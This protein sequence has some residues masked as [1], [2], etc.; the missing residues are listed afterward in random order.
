MSKNDSSEYL[1]E[2]IS[3][4][5]RSCRINYAVGAL[6]SIIILGYSV[7]AFWLVGN[8]TDSEKISN[9]ALYSTARNAP[10]VINSLESTLI[11]QAPEVADSLSVSL[12][13]MIP[14]LRMKA[15]DTL[16]QM[17]DESFETSAIELINLTNAYLDT[18]NFQLK[19]DNETIEVYA[20][21][22]ADT[23]ASDFSQSLEKQLVNTLG[24]TI[25]DVNL[26][27]HTVLTFL[28]KHL[29]ELATT[30]EPSLTRS[31]QLERLLI[32]YLIRNYMPKAIEEPALT[33]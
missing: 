15:Q 23:L 2:Q 10:K 8:F 16:R 25:D 4:L 20:Q 33:E 28:N 29:T 22:V 24:N 18:H 6:L 31:Q 7:F 32:S 19:Q 27:T 17:V 26:S 3:Y 21:R 11:E 1:A 13:H 14:E 12:Q 5:Q 9:F 30:P